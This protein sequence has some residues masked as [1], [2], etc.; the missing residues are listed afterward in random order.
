WMDDIWLFLFD[1]PAAARQAQRELQNAAQEVGL[2]L[3]SAKTDLLEGPHVAEEALNIEH[4]AVDE[5]IEDEADFGKLEEM[6]AR[7]IDDP[8]HAGRT[9]VRFAVARMLKHGVTYREQDLVAVAP[10][11]PHVA[12]TLARLFK[13]RFTTGSLQDW[14]KE[15]AESDWASFSW[16]VAQYGR[17]FA[18]GVKPRQAT[19]E[20]FME[21]LSDVDTELQLAALSAQ[22]L[23]E[24]DAANCRALIADVMRRT[25]NPH[26]RRV[27]SLAGLAAGTQPRTVRNWLRI[28]PENAT[29]LEY[30]NS[31]G[32]HA[33]RTRPT[34]AR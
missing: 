22:R 15:Y 8:D 33:P 7:I 9:T 29:T 30:L 10:R 20:F 28:Q 27:L 31:V 34:F 3:N 1:D 11:M 23:A 12:D 4:S 5:A 16:A 18:S 19:R 26:P 2:H 17:M 32:F 6:I 13:A 24:W 14:F 25:D 21:K